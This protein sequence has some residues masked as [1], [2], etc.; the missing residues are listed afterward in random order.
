M[1]ADAAFLACRTAWKHLVELAI[2]SKREFQADADECMRFFNGPYDFLYGMSDSPQR[3]DFLYVGKRNV[4][5]PNICLTIN[6]AAEL[7][8]LFGPNLYHKNPSCKVNARTAPQLPPELFGDPNDPNIQ[9]QVQPIMQ[10]LSQQMQKDAI[11]AILL[12]GMLNY[13]PDAMGL[14]TDSRAAIDETI[15]K[16]AGFLFARMDNP[17]GGRK[18]AILEYETADNVLFDPDAEV[19]RNAKVAFRRFVKPVWEVEAQ[20]GLPHGTL[21]ANYESYVQYAA[22]EAAGDQYRRKQGKTN[23][24]LVYWGCW[25][26][27]G[28]GGLLKGISP[29]AAELDRYGQYVYVEVCDSYNYFLNVPPEIWDNDQEVRRRLQWE[30]PFWCDIPGS[31][32]WPFTMFKFHEVPRQ[33]WPMSHLRPAMGELKAINWL[34]SFIVSGMQKRSRDFMVVPKSMD[35]ETKDKILE[36][37]DLTLIELSQNLGVPV[38]QLVAFI[39]HPSMPEWIFKVLQTLEVSFEKRTGLSELMY[40]MQQTQDRSATETKTKENFV[41][42]RPDDMAEKVEEA[43]TDAFRKLA[44]M[45]RWHYK[46]ADV[47]QIFGPII[48]QLWT[49]FVETADIEELLHSLEYRIEAGSTRKPNKQKDQQDAK[50]CLQTMMPVISQLATSG[51]IE[52]YNALITFWANAFDIDVNGFLLPKPPEPP[53][54][55]PEPPK[56]TVSLKGEDVLALGLDKSI[57]LDFGEQGPAPDTL[58]P[59][60]QEMMQAEATHK[61]DQRHADEKHKLDQKH[62][63]E[64]QKMDQETAKKKAAAAIANGKK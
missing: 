19:Q 24:L 48:G 59:L 39:Q 52:P 6:K 25:S 3:G 29:D 2:K 51:A 50:D 15:I 13:L 40:G 47:A 16:G 41:N 31:N 61:Q 44:L 58:N 43:M 34:Y 4:S 22:V 11:R 49:Q 23:D 38:D 55:H 17:A 60:A 63:K 7:V 57:R 35:D 33:I 27:M 28:I 37:D 64:K 12:S 1:S 8:Q 5:R 20:H 54:P 62:A 42:V 10:Q 32:G 21:K 30:T 46:G 9:A 45:L 53:P 36:G 18:M 26:K 56:V 14:K